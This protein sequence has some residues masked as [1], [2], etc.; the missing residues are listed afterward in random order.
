MKWDLNGDIL[1][2]QHFSSSNAM[3]NMREFILI[4][5]SKNVILLYHMKDNIAFVSLSLIHQ[6]LNHLNM[7]H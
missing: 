2:Q 6:L 3:R 1:N 4:K 5:G 7:C